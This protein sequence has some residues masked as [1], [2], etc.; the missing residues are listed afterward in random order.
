MPEVK[1]QTTEFAHAD[2]R[3]IAPAA[4]ALLAA[5][6][7]ILPWHDAHPAEATDNR[8]INMCRAAIAKAE[9]G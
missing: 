7:E 2:G 4:P 6:K 8:I 3:F 5:L 9:G 1:S